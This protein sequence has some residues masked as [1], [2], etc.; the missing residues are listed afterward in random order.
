MRDATDIATALRVARGDHDSGDGAA[1]A[2]RAAE[3]EEGNGD[4]G[5]YGA[6]SVAEDAQGDASTRSVL[7]ALLLAAVFTQV[8]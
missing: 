4:D 5:L 2:P 3:G 1:R 7:L 6:V 8:H